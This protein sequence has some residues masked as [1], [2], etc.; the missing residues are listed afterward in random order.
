MFTK[1]LSKINKYCSKTLTSFSVEGER[2]EIYKKP[3][4]PYQNIEEVSINSVMMGMRLSK[5]NNIFPKMRRLDLLYANIYD[6]ICS[7][8]FIKFN[9]LEHL[10]ITYWSDELTEEIIRLNPQLKSISMSGNYGAELWKYISK[11]LK[12][13]KTLDMQYDL[14]YDDND[15]KFKLYPDNLISF[16]CVESLKL[17]ES[18]QTL[19]KCLSF[20]KLKE[21]TITG[22]MDKSWINFVIKNPTIEKLEMNYIIGSRIFAEEDMEK[23]A[24][25]NSQNSL[26]L[27]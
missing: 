14:G 5:L 13:L 15:D 20:K 11:Q 24:K 8:H 4:N 17:Y 19:E 12:Q 25:K 26:N 6:D 22:S 18:F 16:E 9:Q 3:K 21:C 2:S 23:I 10:G 27:T 7:M 1:I